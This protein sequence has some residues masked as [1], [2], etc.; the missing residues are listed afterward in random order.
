MYLYEVGDGILYFTCFSWFGMSGVSE[1]AEWVAGFVESGDVVGLATHRHYPHERL[2]YSRVGV[3]GFCID[4]VKLENGSRRLYTIYV[5]ARAR[6]GGRV[7]SFMSLP[8]EASLT[9]AKQTPEGVEVSVRR[10]EYSNGQELFDAVEAVRRA[11]YRRYRELKAAEARE[12]EPAK[13]GEEVFHQV[14]LTDDELS[15]GV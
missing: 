14:G 15:L 8:G 3:C 10:G 1:L 12:I 5:E 9:I 2:I 4:V 6:V 13:V 11:F 7:G